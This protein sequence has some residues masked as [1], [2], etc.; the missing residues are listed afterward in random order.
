MNLAELQQNN[1]LIRYCC[2]IMDQSD[3]CGASAVR[4][5]FRRDDDHEFAELICSRCHETCSELHNGNKPKNRVDSEPCYVDRD[6]EG[7]PII[8]GAGYN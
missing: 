5:T 8:E 7:Q 6:A 2:T 1:T 4:Y 3:C